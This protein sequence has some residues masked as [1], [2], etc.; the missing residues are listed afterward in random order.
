[1]PNFGFGRSERVRGSV[2]NAVKSFALGAS[3]LALVA[4]TSTYDGSVDPVARGSTA[5]WNEEIMYFVIPDRYADARPNNFDW[6]PTKPGHFHG[7]DWVGLTGQ[8]DQLDEL[9]VTALWITPIVKQIPGYVDGAGFPD[10]GYHGYWAD[11][12]NALDERMGTEAELKELVDQAHARGMK[13]VVDIV[14][15]HPGYG[16]AYTTERPE[17]VREG[18]ACGNDD[19]TGCIGGLPDFKTEDREVRDYVIAAHINWAKRLGFDGYRMDTVKHVDTKTLRANRRKVSAELGRDFFLLGEHWDGNAE[20]LSRLYFRDNTLDGGIDFSFK[21]ATKSW[22][23]GN[24]QTRAFSRGYLARRHDHTAGTVLAHYL[25]SHD[26]P[27]MLYELGGDRDQFRLMAA[28]QFT[29][30]GMPII[31]YGEEVSRKIG[32]WPANRSNMPWGGRNI[33]PGAGDAR[34]ESMRRF[35]KQLIAVRK[36]NPAL[37][38]G[39]YHEILTSTDVLVFGRE[40]LILGAEEDELN[41]VVVLANRAEGARSTT[42]KLPEGWNADGLRDQLSGAGVVVNGSSVTVTVPGQSVSV[43]TSG[44]L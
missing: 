36:A 10:Y 1:M 9:G 14:L 24:S 44:K 22:V 25:S 8:L 35:Y 29:T 37:A 16:A 11:D 28:L 30:L 20:N 26:Q 39:S 5:Q 32:D 38:S 27:G 21:S 23:T 18:D 17:W 19:V 4:C 15:N 43:L 41:Q 2:G 13:V 33:G 31:Y 3:L 34:D 40:K 6:H 12:F 7:G 42:F